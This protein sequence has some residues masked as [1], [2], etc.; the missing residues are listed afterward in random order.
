MKQIKTGM[1]GALAFVAV[2][3][4]T[5]RQADA[6]EDTQDQC[7]TLVD[8][9][10][11]T[12]TYHSQT[13]VGYATPNTNCGCSAA[14]VVPAGEVVAT[15]FV[16]AAGNPTTDFCGAGFHEPT[17]VALQAAFPGL[18]L[19]NAAL[20]AVAAGGV[21][22]GA[23]G[24]IVSKIVNNPNHEA[25]TAIVTAQ[26]NFGPGGTVTVDN[27]HQAAAPVQACTDCAL[28][29]FTANCLAAQQASTLFGG[30]PV[31]YRA[32]CAR[33]DA[34]DHLG[35][36]QP[37]DE[38]GGCSVPGRGSVGGLLLVMVGLALA[39]VRRQRR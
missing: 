24:Y 14:L 33:T 29:P 26:I 2:T 13:T 8:P 34:V 11:P 23:G 7:A 17:Q 30:G 18:P 9:T 37:E 1:L 3:L 16:D 27:K 19:S 12:V 39:I 32:V 35:L 15:V 4:V 20:A 36:D 28:T 6:C 25:P 10:D 21:N 31:P 22:A 38:A 5:E